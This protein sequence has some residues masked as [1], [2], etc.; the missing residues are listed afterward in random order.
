M[1]VSGLNE[2]QIDNYF[3]DMLTME[4][5]EPYIEGAEQQGYYRGLKE[6]ESKGKAEGKA[7][8]LAEGLAK[9]ISMVAKAMLAGGM[10]SE[11]VAK[12]TGMSA[13]DINSLKSDLE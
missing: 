5:M 1:R 9:G 2:G 7:E 8:G 13:E 6:G 3:S 11:V 4:E 10:T 12:V